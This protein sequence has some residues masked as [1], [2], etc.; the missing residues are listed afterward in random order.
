M[1]G[2]VSFLCAQNSRVWETEEM[3]NWDAT[4]FERGD[5]LFG[6]ALPWS[7]YLSCLQPAAQFGRQLGWILPAAN[8]PSSARAKSEPEQHLLIFL[9]RIS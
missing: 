7:A 4:R 1:H 2:S 8:R 6:L 5:A 3:G 9:F